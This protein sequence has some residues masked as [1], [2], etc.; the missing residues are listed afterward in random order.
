MFYLRYVCLFPSSGVLHV[1][2]FLFINYELLINI[3]I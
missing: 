2:L 3:D 1:Y